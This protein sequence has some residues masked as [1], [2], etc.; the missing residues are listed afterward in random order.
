M[1]KSYKRVAM[2]S[3]KNIINLSAA[4]DA[5]SGGRVPPQ[6]VDVEKAVLGAMLIDK[7][8]APKA[9]ELLDPTSFYNPT[10]QKFFLAM[11]SLF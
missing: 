5:V 9:L 10:H 11:Q 7:E 3:P 2:A 1:M 8:A 4:H 6:A